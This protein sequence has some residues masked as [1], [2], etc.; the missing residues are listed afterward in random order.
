MGSIKK[1]IKIVIYASLGLGIIATSTLTKAN[2][3]TE[4]EW[5]NAHKL[6]NYNVYL[7]GNHSSKS[8]DI[9]G[10]MAIKGY[11]SFPNDLKTFSYGAMF[12]QNTTGVGETI[13]FDQQ[14]IALLIGKEVVNHSKAKYP[15]VETRMHNN[16]KVGYLVADTMEWVDKAFHS[17]KGGGGVSDEQRRITNTSSLFNSLDGSVSWNQQYFDEL[18]RDTKSYIEPD[19]KDNAKTLDVGKGNYDILVSEKNPEI[20]VVNLPMK[21]DGTVILEDFGLDYNGYIKNTKIKKIIVTSY[22]KNENGTRKYADKLVVKGEYHSN[23]N[24]IANVLELSNPETKEHAKKLAYYFPETTQVTNFF[25]KS[26]NEIVAPKDIDGEASGVTKDGELMYSEEYLS[27]YRVG[28]DG[29]S[30]A[31]YGGG[32]TIIGSLFAPEATVIFT[33]SSINGALVAKNLHQ[34]NGME[35][36]N[37]Y[38]NWP[39]QEI[40]PEEFLGKIKLVK[41]AEDGDTRLADAEFQ[42]L[43]SKDKVIVNDIKTNESGEWLSDNLAIGEY[44][45]IETKAPE[46]YELDST[47][48]EVTITE[49]DVNTVVV[50]TVTNKL[51]EPEEILGGFRLVKY[52]SETKEPLTGAVFNVMN[53][54]GELVKEK[55]VT[56]NQGIIHVDNLPLGNYQL[57]ETQAPEGYELNETPLEFTITE[58]NETG[59]IV[60]LSFENKPE[61]PMIPIEP[62]EPVGGIKLV[63][64]DAETGEFLPGAIFKIASD[65]ERFVAIVTTNDEGIASVKGMSLGDYYVT[66]VQAPEGYVLDTEPKKVTV[67]ENDQDNMVILE[68]TNKPT[69]PAVPIEPGIPLGAIQ[70][71][72]QDK[73]T[74]EKLAGAQFKI[75]SNETGEVVSEGLTTDDEGKAYHGGLRLGQYQII[76]TVAPAGYE[77]LTEPII[78]TVT[79]N[80]QENLTIATIDNEK[81]PEKEEKGTLKLIKQDKENQKRLANAE[82][83]LKSANGEIYTLITDKNGEAVQ[84]DLAFDTYTLTETKAPKGYEKLT[85]PLTVKVEKN[86]EGNVVVLTVDNEK[87]PTKPTEPTDPTDPTEKPDKPTNKPNTSTN[88]NKNKLPQTSESQGLT[89]ALTAIGVIVIIGIVVFYTKQRKK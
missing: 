13:N 21:S 55:L 1:I 17:Q 61:I 40:E 33:G 30:P 6:T 68:L 23:S 74:K 53:E 88:N 76:E 60:E 89:K 15:T 45:L 48:K 69:I 49:K 16:K 34:R 37:M 44:K 10:P 14:P 31:T 64:K 82:F 20:L 75:A 25:A 51:K 52:D 27:Q 4:T 2:E 87:T 29:S 36:H 65:K 66:E 39:E 63:K 86:A 24:G 5:S 7:K 35:V 85:E 78:V 50:V 42:L 46:G 47:P 32:A 67:K 41:L 26:G 3:L 70:I 59:N 79:G 73:E 83:E 58:N 18:V 81:T 43:D 11:S 56:N 12:T 28:F 22:H 71:V 19:T 72:K 54:R 62:S 80:D 8:A 77:K 9:E 84:S 38:Y 57:I